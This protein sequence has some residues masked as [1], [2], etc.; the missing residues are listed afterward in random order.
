[1]P[2]PAD[3]SLSIGSMSYYKERAQD[4]A[5]RHNG[6]APP[7]YYLGYGDRYMHRFLDE[8]GPAMS[9]QGK[10]WLRSTRAR[11]QGAI[12]AA[13]AQD[14]KAFERLEQDPERFKHFCYRSH[15]LAYVEAGLAKLN[16]VEWLQIMLTPDSADLLNLA[17]L[18][19]VVE[20]TRLLVVERAQQDL[21]TLRLCAPPIAVA[22]ENL[23]K[24][25]Q[26]LA[27]RAGQDVALLARPLLPMMQR[28]SLSGE[29]L[30]LACCPLIDPVRHGLWTS[31]NALAETP[32]NPHGGPP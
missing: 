1:M 6:K 30:V 8:L 11:L 14:P 26:P 20:T 28:L 10:E 31:L 17:G 25:C 9:P 2:V 18:A 19:Q 32:A 3:L 22:L 23:G 21:E 24:A 29:S 4:F 16:P 13:R 5:R 7:D 27:V 15:P 12:E